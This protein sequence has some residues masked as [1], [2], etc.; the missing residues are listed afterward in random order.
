MVSMAKEFGVSIRMYDRPPLSI[1][2]CCWQRMSVERAFLE[3][4]LLGKR[5]WECVLW[6]H[7]I[8]PP[9]FLRGGGG[10]ARGAVGSSRTRPPSRASTRCSCATGSRWPRAGAWINPTTKPAPPP[11]CRPRG[12]EGGGWGGDPQV[13]GL[14]AGPGPGG[15]DPGVGGEWAPYIRSL[16]GA[17]AD[18]LWFHPAE[19]ALLEG[20][21]ASGVGGGNH[22]GFCSPPRSIEHEDQRVHIS[23]GARHR[24]SNSDSRSCMHMSPSTP[25]LPAAVFSPPPSPQAAT[26]PTRRRGCGRSW[27]T[28]GGSSTP[29]PRRATPPCGGTR[30]GPPTPRGGG[31]HF[32]SV[33][34]ESYGY[35]PSRAFLGAAQKVWT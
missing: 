18:P 3:K 22:F 35:R 10:C 23:E 13:G 34:L 5:S 24:P 31:G 1:E 9:R 2:R 15:G 21:P 20:A 16:P 32:T 19:W 6:H 26:S 28:T 8:N 4:Y 7:A 27:R 11:L 25:C 17:F 29:P 30:R 12:R 33:P 14:S